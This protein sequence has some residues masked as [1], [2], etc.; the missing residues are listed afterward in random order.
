[1]K[2]LFLTLCVAF[3]GVSAFAQD[4]FF[5]NVKYD[6]SV[7]YIARKSG[8]PYDDNKAGIHFGVNLIKPFWESSNEK[9]DLYGLAG[10]NYVSKGGTKSQGD[11]TAALLEADHSFKANA[12]SLPIH[13][14]GTW[15]LKKHS[16]FIDLGPYVG[17]IVGGNEFDGLERKNFDFG[18]GFNLGYRFRTFA[19]SVG[20]DKGLLSLGEYTF[21]GKKFDLKSDVAYIGFHW[22]FGGKKNK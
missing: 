2:K 15:Y 17:Y 22:M 20:Y 9:F 14:G 18:V 19:L 10:L 7:S 6:I 1:M 21:E 12:I 5:S 8:E 16:I 11:I 4:S 3:I 13:V